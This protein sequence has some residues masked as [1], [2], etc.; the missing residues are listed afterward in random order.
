MIFAQR[1]LAFGDLFFRA[2]LDRGLLGL[3]DFKLTLAEAVTVGLDGQP[4]V[5]RGFLQGMS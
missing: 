1:Q 2:G 4:L 3:I 5:A